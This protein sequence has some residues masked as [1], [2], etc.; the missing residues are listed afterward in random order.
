VFGNI[1][2]FNASQPLFFEDKTTSTVVNLRNS[3]E[4]VFATDG[5]TQTGRFVLHFQEVGMEDHTGSAFTIWNN[6]QV[7]HITPKTGNIHADQVEIFS[8]TGQLVYSTG[9]LDLPATIQPG[10]LNMGLYILKIE[11]QEGTYTRKLIVR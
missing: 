9:G 2:S 4:F 11:T 3:G 1:E 8:L 10:H 5:S 7:I 6:G